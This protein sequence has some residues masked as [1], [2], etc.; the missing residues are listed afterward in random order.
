MRLLPPLAASEKMSE[1]HF[2]TIAKYFEYI[3]NYF[4]LND[5]QSLDEQEVFL[6]VNFVWT[7]VSIT[8]KT[9]IAQEKADFDGTL[10]I[11]LNMD[12]LP[13]LTA[14]AHLSRK[15]DILGTLFE[16]AAVKNFPNAKVAAILSSGT[17]RTNKTDSLSI[18]RREIQSANSKLLSRELMIDVQKT[19]DRIEAKLDNSEINSSKIS[20]IVQLYRQKINFLNNQM[21]SVTETLDQS[22]KESS[23]LQHKLATAN[24][25]SEKQEFTYW[26]L[27]LDNERLTHETCKL[28]GECESIRSSIAA[29]HSKI[30]KEEAAKRQAMAE[31]KNKAN[32]INR[33]SKLLSFNSLILM[34]LLSQALLRLRSKLKSS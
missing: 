28:L 20:D 30:D 27:Q 29:F 24:K 23:E 5:L 1:I 34:H 9:R 4:T 21:S 13:I 22:T 10:R 12:I 18:Q 7:L 25:I 32:E 16:L 26:C 2:N 6:F 11:V 33:T 17:T 8:K 3:M 14:K 15:E 19:I 31:L